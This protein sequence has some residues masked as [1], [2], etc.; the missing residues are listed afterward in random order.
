MFAYGRSD[1]ISHTH[2]ILLYFLPGKEYSLA[3]KRWGVSDPTIVSLEMLTVG[4]DGPLCLILVYAIV[5]DKPYRHWV[6]I[7]LCTC[8][9]YGGTYF[10]DLVS[11]PEIVRN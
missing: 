6:Q 2:P 1:L 7:V 9:L 5:K 4:L 11:S 3:D 10:V 8:E